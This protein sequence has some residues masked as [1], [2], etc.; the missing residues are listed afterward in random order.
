MAPAKNKLCKATTTNPGGTGST[1][2][3]FRSN[4]NM[5]T[6]TFASATGISAAADTEQANPSIPIR[7][8]IRSGQLV[9]MVAITKGTSTDPSRQIKILC[10]S[11]KAETIGSS[12]G[13]GTDTIPGISAAPITVVRR[14]NRMRLK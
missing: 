10:T 6:G 3:Y 12:F 9:R 7:N 2:V 8:L 4:V 1:V 14:A 13:K 5:Y 11:E